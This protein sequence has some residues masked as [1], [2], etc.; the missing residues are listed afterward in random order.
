ML[1]KPDGKARGQQKG[2]RALGQRA[3][4]TL[5]N[6]VLLGGVADRELMD[7]AKSLEPSTEFSI[8]ELSTP[9]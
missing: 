7:N 3:V 4:E 9:I 8:K 2:T 5:C 1:P 6:S